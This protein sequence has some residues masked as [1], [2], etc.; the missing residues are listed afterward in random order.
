M[1]PVA[2][3]DVGVIF[4]VE[5][6]AVLDS[7][8]KKLYRDVMKETFLNLI[9]IEG[10]LEENIEEDHRDLSRNLGIQVVEKD[11]G[12]QRDTEC[13]ENQES[14]PENMVNHDAPPA[15]TVY[16]SRLLERNVIDDS[17][18]QVYQR[19]QSRSSEFQCQ[20][21]VVSSQLQSFKPT[22][23]WEDISHSESLQVL[24]TSPRD[25][26][27]KN[28][29]CNEACRSLPS[30][31]PQERTH[32]GDNKLSENILKRCACDQK[33]HGIHTGVKPFVCEHCEEAFIESSDL[34]SHEKSHLGERSYICKQHEKTCFEK[35]EVTHREVKPHECKH[36]GKAFTHSSNC[37]IHERSHCA[38]K[39]YAHKHCEKTFTSSNSCNTHERIHTGE[40]LYTCKHC[41]KT[42]ATLSSYDTHERVHTG[43]KPCA[44]KHCGKTFTIPGLHNCH[45]Q[46]HNV[47][48]SYAC[49]HCG[50][51]FNSSEHC[52][53]HERTHTGENIYA[54][55]H[56]G[57]VFS[58]SYYRNIHERI[59]TGEKP[60]SCE[61]CGKAFTRSIY[62]KRH[63]II[64]TGDKPY[65][66]KHCEKSFSTS[67][68]RD[69]HERIHT[70]KKPY[71]CQHCGKA[72]RSSSGQKRHERIHS[73]KL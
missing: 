56:C 13:D 39:P 10:T 15:K 22:K 27:Y 16:E 53:I 30:D 21:A 32:T 9:S 26:P 17:S 37:N 18:L 59:H 41:D 60:Y 68:Y 35:Q 43:E 64:H 72:F 7:G 29:Q 54:C 45:E 4:T 57:Q 61:H 49:K 19:D 28:Q 70:G 40:K 20:E 65:A 67:C 2:F 51:A 46:N 42:F 25:K 14:T 71:A 73:E 58:T 69:L 5:E 52:K 48:T 1:E 24:E 31:Q 36:C 44:C 55:K 34:G 3:A 8:Q 62:L 47:K 11:C 12:Y 23:H 6:W 38:E 50:K 33:D 66:C 63:E